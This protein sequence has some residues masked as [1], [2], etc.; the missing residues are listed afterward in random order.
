VPVAEPF[1]LGVNYWPAKTAM[2]W[3]P[4]YDGAVV[5][6]DFARIAAA[7]MDT[8]RIFV[9]WEDVQPT[10]STIDRRALRA[11]IDTADA[12]SAAGTDL[13]VTLF[14][15]HMSSV[16]WIPPWALGGSDGD[17]RFRVVVGGVVQAAPPSLRNWYSDPEMVTAQTRLTSAVAGALAGHPAVWAWDLGNENS[18]CTVPP[19]QATAEAWLERMTSA[20]RAIDP[21]R[22]IT[23]GLHLENLEQDRV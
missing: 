23:I 19:S 12:A 18:N 4:S 20:I 17:R 6:R 14:T 2:R 1:R 7:G 8:I 5:R 15:G 9:R 10:P 21:G 3:L 16:N 22:P 13:V 11:L